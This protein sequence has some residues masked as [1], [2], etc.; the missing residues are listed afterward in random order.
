MTT[1]SC[2]RNIS[3]SHLDYCNAL[4]ANSTVEVR[5][6]LQRIQNNAVRLICSQPPYTRTT[7][8]LQNLHWL[9]VEKRIVYKLCVL[10]FDVK[11]GSAPAYLADLCNICTDERLCSTSRGHFVI[12][13]TRTCIADSVFMVAAPSAWN[14]LPSE[15][16]RITSKT[17]FHN[18]LKTHLFSS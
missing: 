10:M 6:W 15:L 13:R 18:R 4:F 5:Q 8:L 11:Y 2:I 12:L 16:R 1:S 7:P 3:T 14:A 17:I 9:L